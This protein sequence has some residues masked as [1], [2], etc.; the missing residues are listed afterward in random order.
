MSLL[1]VM[2]GLH[3]AEVL[4][5]A[6]LE[7][8]F[9]RARHVEQRP[10]DFA[11]ALE[12]RIIAHVFEEPSTRTRLSFEAAAHRLGARVL[13]VSDPKSS[14]GAKGESLHDAA[15]V[16]GG[17]CDLMV[18]RHAR[19]GASRL[20]SLSAGVPV[21]NGGDGRLGHPTQ[22]LVDLYTLHR[23]WEGFRGRT[24]AIAGDLL[25]GRTA[26]S[27]AWGLA[28]LG[29]RLVLLPGPGL[30]WESSFDRRLLDRFDYRLR[31]C[32]HR[33]FETWTGTA[34]ARLLEP[35]ELVQPSLF[36]EDA[37]VLSGL[38]AL[39][40]TRL[41]SERGAEAQDRPYCRLSA[42]DLRDPLLEE[43][44]VLHP[45]PRLDEL[46][47]ELD[48]DPRAIWFEQARLGP[49]VRQVVFLA[50]LHEDR[51]SLPQLAPLPAGNPDHELGNCPNPSCIT[52]AEGLPVPWRVV[53]R[54]RR[55]FLCA[56]CD[57]LLPVDYAGCRSTHRV[58]PLHSPA[59]MRIAPENLR[60]FRERDAAESAGYVWGG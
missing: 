11:G 40:M 30:D 12:G 5:P 37:P 3:S 1:P 29:V 53:G 57:G 58:H 32:R 20:A 13:T 35:R 44:L 9:R 59:A 24:V 26:R 17:Y 55:S 33:L 41:Q 16:I 25:H 27:L 45:L 39:Y 34:E 56:F 60:P 28:T 4:T 46:P 8:F 36:P 47:R 50:M 14:S 43:C 48:D 21:V 31:R 54:A 23:R 38:D 19:D 42:S 6:F 7:A 51:W 10:E 52:R 15:K 22:T 2:E 18:L 49:V